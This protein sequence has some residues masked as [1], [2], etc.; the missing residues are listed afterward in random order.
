ML[1]DGE[2]RVAIRS[3][4]SEQSRRVGEEM[5]ASKTRAEREWE[6]GRGEEE[7]ERERERGREDV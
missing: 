4:D 5:T 2:S 7:D 6:R 1:V 3:G